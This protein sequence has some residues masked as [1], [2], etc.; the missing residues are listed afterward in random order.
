VALNTGSGHYGIPFASGWELFGLITLSVWW[1]RLGIALERIK[2]GR[3][4]KN[5]RYERMHLTLEKETTNPA[6][7]NTLQQQARFDTF[8]K[9]FNH[10]RP[11]QALEMKTPGERYPPSPLPYT[12][13]GELTY[14]FHDKAIA[15]TQCGRLCIDRKKISFSKA[16]AGQTVGA[17]EISESIYLVTFMH[18]DLGFFDQKSPDFECAPN[19]FSA[20]VLPM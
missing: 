13:I 8:L 1:L 3:P 6:G 14:P 16:L 19:P 11:H 18:Y 17:K 5:G 15:I 2:L 10:Q 4:Q 20:T 7:K 12:D 9:E